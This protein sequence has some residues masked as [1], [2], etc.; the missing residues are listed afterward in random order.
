ML[1]YCVVRLSFFLNYVVWIQA[2][3]IFVYVFVSFGFHFNIIVLYFIVIILD[4][5][6]GPKFTWQHISDTSCLCSIPWL[7]FAAV[8]AQKWRTTL[9]ISLQFRRNLWVMFNFWNSDFSLQLPL[10]MREEGKWMF[11]GP[12]III[13]SW[14][15]RLRECDT[16]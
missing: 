14:H 11:V 15:D 8:L 1:F 3:F 10:R 6:V 2:F 4:N 13:K 7:C 9:Q 16:F 5:V 12:C